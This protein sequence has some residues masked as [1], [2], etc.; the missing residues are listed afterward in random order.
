MRFVSGLRPSPAIVVACLSLAASLSGVAY[1]AV[2]INTEDI[3]RGA[4]TT[5]KLD[6]KAVTAGKLAPGAV[7]G[8]KIQRGAVGAKKLDP[9]VPGIAAAGASVTRSGEIIAQFNRLGGPLE[10]LQVNEGAYFVK[11]PGLTN[12]AAFNDPIPPVVP[13]AS[14]ADLE[15]GE[16]SAQTEYDRGAFEVV[17]TYD[18]SGNPA[19]RAFSW[20]IYAPSADAG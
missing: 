5:K 10:V 3:Q 16:I 19:D 8:G 11:V 9:S 6:S 18:S 2:T 7:K 12:T 1:A 20:T 14:L 4:V 15:G 17:R 13:V